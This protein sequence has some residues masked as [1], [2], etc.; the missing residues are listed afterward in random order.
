M[1]SEGVESYLYDARRTTRP[2]SAQF[3]CTNERAPTY[4]SVY[5]IQRIITGRL[6]RRAYLPGRL[7]LSTTA[8]VDYW[9]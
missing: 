3:V 2:V 4:T 9:V 1:R 5:I 7:Y 8:R 6:F